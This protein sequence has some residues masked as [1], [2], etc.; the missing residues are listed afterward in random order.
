MSILDQIVSER[1]AAIAREGH[2]AGARIPSARAVPVIPFGAPPFLVCE[3]KRR[4]PSRGDIAPGLDAVAQ[5]RLY[6]QAGVRSISVLTERDHFEIGRA[7][8]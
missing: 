6:A 8:V 1:R 2:S 4:S 7:H 5:A 3:V